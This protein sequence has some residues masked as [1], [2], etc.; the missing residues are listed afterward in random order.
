[1]AKHAFDRKSI[2]VKIEGQDAS[3]YP[4]DYT[5]S[6]PSTC[7]ADG[8]ERHADTT[9]QSDV[10]RLGLPRLSI[11]SATSSP[12]NSSLNS[13]TVSSSTSTTSPESPDPE[14]ESSQSGPM[15]TKVEGDATGGTKNLSD[16]NV[17]WEN[18]DAAKRDQH[19]TTTTA[20]TMATTSKVQFDLS[21]PVKRGRGRPRKHPLPPPGTVPKAVKGRSKTGC[22]T[23]RRRKKKCGEEKPEC[24]PSMVC[25]R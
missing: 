17:P 4:F 24:I 8:F 18:M 14:G 5:R 9:S 6:S 10:C 20:T 7:I 13:G 2:L 16:H 3:T 23:C 19:A 11:S 15:R 12:N 1:M 21:V 25:I 22:L